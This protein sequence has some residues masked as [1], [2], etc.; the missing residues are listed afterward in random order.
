MVNSLSKL[1]VGIERR[2]T[3]LPLLGIDPTLAAMTGGPID[4][5]ASISGH[6]FAEAPSVGAAWDGVP[7]AMREDDEHIDVEAELPGLTDRDVDIA[8]R[9]ER[10]PEEGRTHPNEDRCYGRFER[11]IPLPAAVATDAVRAESKG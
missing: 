3:M 1:P 10:K 6:V 8:I 4:R 11:A 7:M 2:L 5:L 9:G